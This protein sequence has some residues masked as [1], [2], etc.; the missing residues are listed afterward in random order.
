V[1]APANIDPVQAQRLIDAVGPP[2]AVH[3]Q[4]RIQP[5]IKYLTEQAAEPFWSD[6]QRRGEDKVEAVN[7]AIDQLAT[8]VDRVPGQFQMAIAEDL[9]PA[10]AFVMA[11]VALGELQKTM[12]AN[13]PPAKQAMKRLE[14]Q[15]TMDAFE[16]NL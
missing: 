15:L 10:V 9:N 13:Y 14:N 6:R 4:T 11:Q 1:P 2:L 3:I 7:R 12:L 5:D 16:A 8:A